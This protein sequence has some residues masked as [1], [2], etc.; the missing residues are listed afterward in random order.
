VESFCASSGPQ[1]EEPVLRGGKATLSDEVQI[2][3]R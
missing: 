1:T 3:F 2:A